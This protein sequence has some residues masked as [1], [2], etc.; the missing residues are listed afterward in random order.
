MDKVYV[1]KGSLRCF[2]LAFFGLIPILGI[3]PAL[4]A[5]ATFRNVQRE[6]GDKWN[7]AK[8]YLY[9]GYVLSWIGLLI[10]ILAMWILLAVL[11]KS[12]L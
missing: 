10:S 5:M 3:I 11:L 2:S 6:L 8:A 7:P 1:I 12:M 9:S 4:I